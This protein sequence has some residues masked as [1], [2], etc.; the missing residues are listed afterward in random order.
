MRILQVVG[1]LSPDGAFGGPARVAINQSVEL[2]AR[3]HDV[4]L[5]AASRG[6]RVPPT[7]VEGVRA[8][9]F[10]ARTII[11]TVG[12]PGT[13]S[14]GLFRWFRSNGPGFDIVHIHFGRDLVAVPIAAAALRN[15]VP[16]VLQTHGMVIP[17]QHPLALPLDAVWTKKLLRDAGTVLYLTEKEREQLS[18]VACSP[19]RL[20]QL[21]NGVPDYLPVAERSARPEVLFVA[22]MHARKR[23]LMFV[24]MAKALLAQ[25]VDAQFTLIGPDEGEGPALR[26]A[27]ENESRISWEGALAPEDVP[28]R[29]SEADIYVLPSEREP[30]PMTV[31]EAMVVGLPIVVAADCGLAPIVQS[32]QCGVVVDG[33][34]TAFA[35]AVGA[36]LADRSRRVEMGELARKTAHNVFG[37]GVIGDRLEQLYREVVRRKSRP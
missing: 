17:S 15:R 3:G 19:L 7:E 5:A 36:L 27:L 4:T 24:D 10:K 9:L 18:E 37:M 29:M 11:P 22:R 23:P 21:G 6:F 34:A 20:V 13:G 2:A 35:D 33:E 8:Q 14:P 12:F 16:Y 1:L 26:V 32:A 31:L 28:G 25:G 30:Y